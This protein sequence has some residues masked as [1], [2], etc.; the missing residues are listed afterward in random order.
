MGDV[1]GRL[2][3]VFFLGGRGRGRGNS[4][5]WTTESFSQDDTSLRTSLSL[6]YV[7]Y[8]KQWEFRFIKFQS[9]AKSSLDLDVL[10]WH[11]RCSSVD[12]STTSSTHRR[13][14]RCFCTSFRQG[15]HGA[16]GMV[17]YA[18]EVYVTCYFCYM[19]TLG[20]SLGSSDSVRIYRRVIFGELNWWFAPTPCT[21]YI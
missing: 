18:H 7:L 20:P 17:S 16:V 5:S 1:L 11:V 19:F 13:Q 12:N 2:W 3:M 21:W 14:C 15:L 8:I 9:I 6:C 4:R 10:D